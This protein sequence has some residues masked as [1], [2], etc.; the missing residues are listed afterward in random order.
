LMA[1][2]MSAVK[3]CMARVTDAHF[4]QLLGMVGVRDLRIC[5]RTCMM[6]QRCGGS[7][8]GAFSPSK[9]G[10]LAF[11]LPCC[12]NA[13]QRL[14]A[15]LRDGLNLLYCQVKSLHIVVYIYVDTYSNMNWLSM[16]SSAYCPTPFYQRHCNEIL[17]LQH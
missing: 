2:A 4:D 5:T 13:P 7:I 16:H 17:W 10:T 14:H 6:D 9:K 1:P 8:T 12:G 3:R 11:P 15:C